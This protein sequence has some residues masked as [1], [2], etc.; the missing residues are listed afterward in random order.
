MRSAG[1][2]G[3]CR[4]RRSV[5]PPAYRPRRLVV[6][7]LVLAVLLFCRLAPAD[8]GLDAY[9]VAVGIYTKDEWKL[10]AAN[11]QACLKDH[12]DHPAKPRTP[13]FY[14]GL[15]GLLVQKLRRTSS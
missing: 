15:Q 10:A 12:G 2:M 3:R 4:D 8:E 14:Y 9:R 13:G 5:I 11:F 7:L 6:P 1:K